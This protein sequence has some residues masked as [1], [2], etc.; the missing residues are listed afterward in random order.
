MRSLGTDGFGR[1]GTREGLRDFFE[2]DYR[3]I[4][5]A[6]LHELVAEGSVDKKV[7]SEAINDMG[8]DV[9]KPNPIKY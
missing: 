8:I 7:M 1:S 5:L 6:A 4:V 2:V 3:Y 9:N